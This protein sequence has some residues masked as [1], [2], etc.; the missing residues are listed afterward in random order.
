MV[1]LLFILMHLKIIVF[2][3][4]LRTKFPNLLF[5]IFI[6]KCQPFFH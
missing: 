2:F 3:Q 5:Y 4:K 1:S 6:Y